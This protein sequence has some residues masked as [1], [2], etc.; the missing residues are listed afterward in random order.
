MEEKFERLSKRFVN[1]RGEQLSTNRGKYRPYDYFCS[2][3][4]IIAPTRLL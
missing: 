3:K 1:A 4:K 2:I